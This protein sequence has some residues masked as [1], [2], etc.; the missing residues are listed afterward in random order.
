[1]PENPDGHFGLAETYRKSKRSTE[2]INSYKS[3]L[4]NEKR[5]KEAKWVRKAQQ[6]ILDLG[7]SL[8]GVTLGFLKQP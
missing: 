4:V 5:K 7:G 8:N 6:I 2:A 1:M 3:Y